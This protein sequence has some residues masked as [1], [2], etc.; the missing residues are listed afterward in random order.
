LHRPVFAGVIADIGT[1]V[2]GL[3]HAFG[4]IGID[5]EIVVVTVGCRNLLEGFTTVLGLVE[6][7]IHHINNIL[8]HG[9]GLDPGVIPGPLT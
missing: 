5:P 2:V 3:D 7:Y 8:I 9:I 1:T 6:A 4:I